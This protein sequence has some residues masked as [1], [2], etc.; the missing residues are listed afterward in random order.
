MATKAIMIEVPHQHHSKGDDFGLG[1]EQEYSI[2][3]VAQM[4]SKN[5]TMLPERPGNRMNSG[6]DTSKSK[7]L[8]WSA[9]HKLE[10]YVKEIIGVEYGR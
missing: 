6:I 7:A 4:F 8:G 3:E 10:D 5:I 2:L 9:R 1:S